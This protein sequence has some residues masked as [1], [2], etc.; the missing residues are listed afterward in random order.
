MRYHGE[1]L[2]PCFSPVCLPLPVPARLSPRVNCRSLFAVVPDAQATSPCRLGVVRL[3]PILAVLSVPWQA[4]DAAIV[5]P[6]TVTTSDETDRDAQ[7]AQRY[8][9]LLKRSPKQGTALDKVFEYHESRGSVDSLVDALQESAAAESNGASQFVLGLVQ[10][11]RGNKSAAGLAL[12]RAAEQRPDD[13]L[14]M[15]YR[16]QVSAAVSQRQTAI[17]QLESALRADLPAVHEETVYPLLGRL[18]Q[19]TGQPAQ[20]RETWQRFEAA[21]PNDNAVTQQVAEL[22]AEESFFEAAL[23]RYQRLVATAKDPEQRMEFM[24]AATDIKRALERSDEAREDLVVALESVKPS[25]WLHGEIQDRLEDLYLSDNDAAGLIRF[26]KSRLAANPAD[27]TTAQK[28]ARLLES[29]GSTEAAITQLRQATS[30]APSDLEL[31]MLFVDLLE[32][33][34]QYKPAADEC[35][36]LHREHPADI[37][38]LAR[39]GQLQLSNGAAPL[40]ERRAAAESIW[41]Q[42]AEVDPG[43]ASHLLRIGDLLSQAERP[44]A[45]DYYRQAVAAAPGDVGMRE[46][47]GRWLFRAGRR[48]EAVG[49]WQ[50][51]AADGNPELRR[52]LAEIYGNYGLVAEQLETLRDLSRQA[53][54]FPD[55]IRLAQLLQEKASYVEAR[56]TLTT[57]AARVSTDAELRTLLETS[58]ALTRAAKQTRQRIQTLSSRLQTA[59]SAADW[60]EVALLHSDTRSDGPAL[61]AINAAATLKPQSLLYQSLAAELA[62]RAGR[63][64]QAITRHRALATRDVRESSRHYRKVVELHRRLGQFDLALAAGST[65][66]ESAPANVS[67]YQFVADMC[68]DLGKLDNARDVLQRCVDANPGSVAALEALAGNLAARFRTDEAMETY[69]SALAL[70]T[71][72]E[73]R[74]TI[75]VALTD[76]AVRS[77]QLAAFQPR[78]DRWADGLPSAQSALL[79]AAAARGSGNLT[80]ATEILSQE[81]RRAPRNIETLKT[82]VQLCEEDDNF[83]AAVRFQQQLFQVTRSP[84][85]EHRLGNLIVRAAESAD[86]LQDWLQQSETVLPASVVLQQADRLMEANRF[87]EAA[88]FLQRLQSQSPD[89]WEALYRLAFIAAKT[90]KR[91]ECVD[92]CQRI[93][94]LSL[95]AS[96]PT[97][98]TQPGTP[99]GPADLLS[100]IAA[101]RSADAVRRRIEWLLATSTSSADSG[102]PPAIPQRPADFQSFGACHLETCLLWH[103]NADSPPDLL[104]RGLTA[105]PSADPRLPDSNLWAWWIINQRTL[106]ERPASPAVLQFARQLLINADLQQ[107]EFQMAMLLTL[108]LRQHARSEVEPLPVDLQEPWLTAVRAAA[109]NLPAEQLDRIDALGIGAELR[110]LPDSRVQQFLASLQTDTAPIAWREL[111]LRLSAGFGGTDMRQLETLSA[112]YE[113]QGRIPPPTSQL[114]RLGQIFYD[115]IAGHLRD[116]EP[117]AA[118]DALAAFLRLRV[119]QPPPPPGPTTPTSAEIFERRNIVIKSQPGLFQQRR[120]VQ[121]GGRLTRDDHI[122]LVNLRELYAAD[123]SELDRI[124]AAQTATATGQSR[125]LLELMTAELESLRGNTSSAI[126]HMIRAAAADPNNVSLRVALAG[127]YGQQG[128]RQDALSL[129]DTI[130]ADEQLLL[131]QRETLALEYAAATGRTE[132][133]R[134]AARRLFG[135]RLSGKEADALSRRMRELGLDAQADALRDRQRSGQ[136]NT[137]RDKVAL[138]NSESDSV[139]AEIAIEIL[140][141]TDA[142]VV[143]WTN[144]ISSDKARQAAVRVLGQ[145]GRLGELIRTAEQRLQNAPDSVRLHE[146]L[147]SFYL[148]SGQQDKAS[149]M[150]ARLNVLSPETVDSMMQTAADFERRKE[151]ES[152]ADKYLQVFAKDPLRFAQDYFRYLRLFDEANR[153]PEIADL[154][155]QPETLQRLQNHHH[156]VM[157]TVQFLF[158]TSNRSQQSRTRHQGLK[159]FRAAW[160]QFPNYRRSIVSNIHTDAMWELP[161]LVEYAREGLIPG[162]MQQ[163]IAR[164]WQGLAE[165]LDHA[166][167]GSIRGT[168]TRIRASLARDP[169][170]ASEYIARV[171]TALAEYSHWHGGRVLLCVLLLDQNQPDQALSQLE[172]IAADADALFMPVH[173]AWLLSEEILRSPHARLQQPAIELLE[174]VR[175]REPAFVDSVQTSVSLWLARYYQRQQ[176][177][178]RAVSTLENS[179]QKATGQ[180]SRS[181]GPASPPPSRRPDPVRTAVL[182]LDTAAALDQMGYAFHALRLAERVTPSLFADP[183]EK[184]PR[185]LL[186]RARKAVASRS[187]SVQAAIAYLQLSADRDDDLFLNVDHYGPRR[188]RLHSQ[189]L[190]VILSDRRRRIELADVP[191]WTTAG[192]DMRVHLATAAVVI[193]QR[194]DNERL[195]RTGVAALRQ[196]GNDSQ[197]LPLITWLAVR[198]LQQ[199]PQQRD[200]AVTLRDRL[201]QE[202][203][204]DSPWKQAA[205]LAEAAEQVAGERP[206]VSTSAWNAALDLLLAENARPSPTPGDDSTQ[207]AEALRKL[208]LTPATAH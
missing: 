69:W 83:A 102:L 64:E 8:L 105:D 25:S 155:L 196:H 126:L 38:V 48:E 81:L 84:D 23:E 89:H 154:M 59:P 24:L 31:G 165:K 67:N 206:D 200:L 188:G 109:V 123:D 49:V 121:A 197:T 46:S 60:A 133:V 96:L 45:E 178:E 199:R 21:F 54:E 3:L 132:R 35:R 124:L 103:A 41:Q 34:D 57:A 99:P 208:L 68:L 37:D 65:L 135:L 157:E 191:A 156:V 171:K 166:A 53:A 106:M 28:L 39:W 202:H 122:F 98:L 77:G 205:A 29:E 44:L 85:D 86:S 11:R 181:G 9:S 56:D 119:R 92:L 183:T 150:R 10:W 185:Q 136:R 118:R 193:G 184:E 79:R 139:A 174:R 75:V 87:A 104:K 78:L 32:R 128:N 194:Q 40:E 2:P 107:P 160:Q 141:Q 93:D 130:P 134:T 30:Q 42:I 66:L 13:G 58:V 94:G 71:D 117:D 131:Q 177:H 204:P 180:S 27:T 176:N 74:R 140:R 161:E 187:M 18:Y 201:L 70:T 138:M 55:L 12:Q 173:V 20:A 36:R 167:D 62:E 61:D 168:L 125:V 33:S 145:A 7:L 82:L 203:S 142:D 22:L 95:P 47:L 26:W 52:R 16:G 111:S 115:R 182:T 151:N 80:E 5:T 4:V 192:A 129:L 189:V 137:L 112:A 162:S 195:L 153:L 114:H 72:A 97:Q 190:D 76:L 170:L 88:E 100:T 116:D 73:R 158:A 148:A 144:D 163:S 63:W 108:S 51:I 175:A 90:G 169:Q 172:V 146:E 19:Q 159:L 101:D 127:W 149:Q 50:Q 143:S 6:L 15:M 186:A 179:L 1:A 207:A 120:L 113:Q 110:R 164:P 147:L 152:A 43:N 17:D 198:A 14:L 91:S